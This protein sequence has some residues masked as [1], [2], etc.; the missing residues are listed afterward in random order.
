MYTCTCELRHIY[1]TNSDHI[2][3]QHGFILH[4]DYAI[5]SFNLLLPDCKRHIARI[6]PP[7]NQSHKAIDDARST[8]CPPSR[9]ANALCLPQWR[10][11]ATFCHI[12]LGFCGDV[13]TA[14]SATPI[15]PSMGRWFVGK[16][17]DQ[18]GAADSITAS[19][20]AM[21]LANMKICKRRSWLTPSVSN[22]YGHFDE[23]WLHIRLVD[24]RNAHVMSTRFD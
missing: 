9:W 3:Q 21:E 12:V 15:E 16:S 22:T 8:L 10:I 11:L 13:W 23:R 24:W 6:Y 14:V 20:F 4:Y 17:D 2:K 19:H 5:Y 1:G 7:H 18:S